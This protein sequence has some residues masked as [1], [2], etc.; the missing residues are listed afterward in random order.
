LLKKTWAELTHPDDLAAD[1]AQFNRVMAGRIDGYT[2]DK[3]WVRKDGQVID[4][5][6]AA[7]SLRRT[8]GSVDYFVGLVQDITE[9]KRAET[10]TEALKNALAAELAAMIRLYEFSTLLLA[11]TELKPLLEEVL[12]AIMSIQK[13]NFGYIQLFDTETNALEI[14]AQRGFQQD[15]LDHFGSVPDGQA[16]GHALRHRERMII[17]DVQTDPA[18]ASH[19]QIA[20]ASGVRAVQSTPLFSRRGELLGVMSTYFRQPHRPSEGD[21]RLT[22]LY[23]VHAAEMIERKQSETALLRYQQ[24]LQ[25]L[26]GRLIEAQEMEGKYTNQVVLRV[27]NRLFVR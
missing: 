1:D 23:A 17:E 22:D 2:L 7:N 19:R 27:A 4:T 9:R 20:A 5:V 13:A 16:G 18:F 12:N 11:T 15:F 14:V 26:T 3:R 8:D 21:L 10:E 24:E 25:T 6:M